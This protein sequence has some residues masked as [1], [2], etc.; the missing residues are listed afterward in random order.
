M[1][2]NA[3]M[4]KVMCLFKQNSGRYFSIPYDKEAACCNA[5]SCTTY[6]I[7]S[8]ASM[9]SSPLCN[10]QFSRQR[11]NKYINYMCCKISK[12]TFCLWGLSLR[13]AV[14]QLGSQFIEDRPLT[15]CYTAMEQTALPLAP[16]L[17]HAIKWSAQ[18][19]R[20]NLNC[21]KVFT[22]SHRKTNYCQYQNRTSLQS[23][24][25]KKNTELLSTSSCLDH[26]K[27]KEDR[28]GQGS[29]EKMDR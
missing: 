18:R 4:K 24:Q 20:A 21:L 26:N 2:T 8:P 13:N 29:V 9:T 6:H 3:G 11:C 28:T 22:S 12:D 23:S 15:W 5:L 17:R 27:K 25:Q 1:A 14:Q 10:L 19:K 7:L 16:A